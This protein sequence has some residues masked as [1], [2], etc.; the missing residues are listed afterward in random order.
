MS[1]V[2][3]EISKYIGS[4][5]KLADIWG[6][7]IYNVK[8]TAYGA[9]GNGSD[10]TS[11]IQ[12]TIN[13]AIA[14]NTKS[15][16]FP[17]GTYV[18]TTLTGLD[19]VV[20]LGDNATLTVGGSSVPITQLGAAPLSNLYLQSLING[21]FDIWQRGTSFTTGGY[22]ADRWYFDSANTTTS[23]QSSGA[24]V[25]SQF[26]SRMTMTGLG[27]GNYYQALESDRCAKLAGKTV[28]FSIKMRRNAFFASDIVVHIQKNATP[29]TL[30][31]GTWT[32]FA[33]NVFANATIPVGTT[34]SDWYTASITVVIPNDSTAKGIR[35][36][37]QQATAQVSGA[38]YEISQ[39]QICE[40]FAALPFQPK[41]YVV[42]LA[43]CKRFCH[44]ITDPANANFVIGFGTAGTTTVALIGVQL[45]VQMRI[46]P[47]LVATV[48][49]WQLSDGGALVALT[50]IG[51]QGGQNDN[52]FVTIR[53][54]VASGLTLFRP[55]FLMAVVTTKLMIFD[56]EI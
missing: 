4:A 52:I 33:S 26:Y 23:R 43:D 35:V 9:K 32:T 28:T 56:A 1:T 14:N 13:A 51:L 45:P 55:Y 34:S 46:V 49:D 29:D 11:A 7:I 22:G 38:Y 41:S 2:P 31:G 18:A 15:V 37:I 47:T 12:A 17:H 5:T 3:S 24:P 20:L 48:T 19:S 50:S 16:F 53:A 42:E 10:E 36:F 30:L 39:A 8:D 25:G 40:G 54:T 6:S 21:N 27:N 44:V